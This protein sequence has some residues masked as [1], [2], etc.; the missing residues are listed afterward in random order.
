MKKYTKT[1][2]QL[3]PKNG[4]KISGEI[5]NF[6]IICIGISIVLVF[7]LPYLLAVLLK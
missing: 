2:V 3:H 5:P 1:E 6:L 4:L 7:A